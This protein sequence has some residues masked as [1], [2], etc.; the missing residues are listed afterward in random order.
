MATLQTLLSLAIL[1]V[2][3]SSTNAALFK[4]PASPPVVDP[5][6]EVFPRSN[7]TRLSPGFIE[8]PCSS[9][10]RGFAHDK[11]LLEA[12]AKLITLAA[13]VGGTDPTGEHAI[14]VT[15]EIYDEC[16]RTHGHEACVNW[17]AANVF[18]GDA[19]IC[20]SDR[21]TG[22]NVVADGPSNVQTVGACDLRTDTK[23]PPES[24]DIDEDAAKKA[25]ELSVRPAET[26][27]AGPDSWFEGCVAIEH[28]RGANLH[29]VRH[30]RRRVLCARGFCATANHALLINNRWSSMKQMCGKRGSWN[31]TRSIKMVNNLSVAYHSR[32]RYDRTI[33]ITPFDARFPN[34]LIWLGQIVEDLIHFIGVAIVFAVLSAAATAIAAALVYVFQVDEIDPS[35]ILISAA[36]QRKLY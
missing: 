34:I 16:V 22:R 13:A 26:Q 36:S 14:K 29:H 19:S 33:V 30:L 27:E 31:C 7:V 24:L 21:D 25:K 15:Q 10:W 18:V 17:D 3:T 2:C 4:S 1:V 9:S 5:K 12:R 8:C 6:Q 35:K 11:V 28:L 32:W 23:S 20:L